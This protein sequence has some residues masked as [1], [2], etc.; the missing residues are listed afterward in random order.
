MIVAYR[1]ANEGKMLYG[2]EYERD[3]VASERGSV[4]ENYGMWECMKERIH[5]LPYLST[6]L[7]RVW[8]WLETLRIGNTRVFRVVL[9]NKW[10]IAGG[11]LVVTIYYAWQLLISLIIRKARIEFV[12]GIQKSILINYITFHH[13]NKRA[14]SHYPFYFSLKNSWH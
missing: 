2:R 3:R 9:V 14:N 7:L 1:D 5:R 12:L 11:L 8:S 6:S 13:T 10:V 4:S